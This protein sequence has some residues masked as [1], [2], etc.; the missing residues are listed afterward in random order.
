MLILGNKFEG[1]LIVGVK[2]SGAYIGG[3]ITGVDCISFKVR[4]WLHTPL[5]FSFYHAKIFIIICMPKKIYRKFAYFFNYH[6]RLQ[7]PNQQFCEDQKT[8]SLI[9]K[10]P[11]LENSS[12]IERLDALT[13]DLETLGINT[14]DEIAAS[15]G[16]PRR[17]INN[18]LTCHFATKFGVYSQFLLTSNLRSFV[19]A[20]KFG[21]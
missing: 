21:L 12:Q 1:F 9:Q 11:Q 20:K 18:S 8:P 2:K 19:N 4:S 17:P 10:S 14:F 3:A 13:K 7:N 5:C 6:K 15:L 16:A